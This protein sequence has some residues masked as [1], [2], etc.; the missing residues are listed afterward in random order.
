MP[1]I[2]C[3]KDLKQ[4]KDKG[5][6]CPQCGVPVTNSLPPQLGKDIIAD[7][8]T[9]TAGHKIRWFVERSFSATLLIIRALGFA[10]A[11]YML[12][13]L[14]IL[15]FLTRYAEKRHLPIDMVL[16]GTFRTPESNQILLLG[17]LICAPICIFY[18]VHI[19]LK[20]RKSS[21][22]NHFKHISVSALL[23]GISYFVSTWYVREMEQSLTR[24]VMINLPKSTLDKIL[25]PAPLLPSSNLL[26][27]AAASNLL[28][29]AGPLPDGTVKDSR[30]KMSL[31]I[32]SIPYTNFFSTTLRTNEPNGKPAEMVEEEALAL[33][34][35]KQYEQ[36]ERVALKALE[37]TETTTRTNSTLL[38]SPLN[39]LSQMYRAQNKYQ[40]A[41]LCLL[42]ALSIIESTMTRS[43]NKKVYL[44]PR[45]D[46][47]ALRSTDSDWLN[48]RQVIIGNLIHLYTSQAKHERAVEFAKKE[49]E[50]NETIIGYG[51][52]TSKCLHRLAE[53]YRLQGNYVSA[54]PLYHRALTMN[55]ETE[56]LMVEYI[57]ADLDALV[58]IYVKRKDY[59]LAETFCRKSLI[60]CEKYSYTFDAMVVWEHIENLAKL[61]KM[62]NKFKQAETLCTRVLQLYEQ[63]L[64]VKDPKVASIL[65]E[66]AEICRQTGRDKEA[67]LLMKRA[68]RINT[69]K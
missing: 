2:V 52:D 26:L 57:C 63:N 8:Q 16:D 22:G 7:A 55:N 14:F 28:A 43:R 9:E 30:A 19:I 34:F 25:H 1:N 44:S 58:D 5:T 61:Y 50:F 12:A 66:M 67:V 45:V 20:Y 13:V 40:E 56:C 53:L 64:G 15:V 42:K 59:I 11:I 17:T 18:I 33:Y 68:D 65:K 21:V 23:I 49:L 46:V 29:Y 24:A 60:I 69:Q 32:T 35:K 51:T 4:I 37:I 39:T 31:Y 62:Q 38:V 36:G 3:P 6:T 54:E 48:A 10:C 47:E 41:E 27:N